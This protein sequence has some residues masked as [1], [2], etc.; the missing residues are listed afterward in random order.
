MLQV[1]AKLEEDVRDSATT[2]TENLRSKAASETA[3]A[4]EVKSPVGSAAPLQRKAMQPP[5]IM[6]QTLEIQSVQ[7]RIRQFWGKQHIAAQLLWTE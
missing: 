1:K 6:S 3:A 4:T 5:F 2:G 7:T